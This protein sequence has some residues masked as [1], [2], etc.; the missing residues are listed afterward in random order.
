[1]TNEL[2]TQ[3]MDEKNADPRIDVAIERTLL[4][5]ERTQLAWTR[6][7]LALLTSGI[8]IDKGFAALHEARILEGVAWE[9]NGHFAGLLLT[10]G[11]TFLGTF[12]AIIL[13]LRI[14]K[15]NAMLTK[16]NTFPSPGT[17]LSFFICIVGVLAIY[18]LLQAW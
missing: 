6:T 11:G 2:L 14:R 17:V 18:F 8:A 1:M 10:A 16:P 3:A 9:K 7:V 5:V 12:A 4:A 15:L 13:Y